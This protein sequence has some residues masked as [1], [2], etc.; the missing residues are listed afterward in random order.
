MDNPQLQELIDSCDCVIHTAGPYYPDQ[1]PTVLEKVIQSSRCQVYLDVS[2]PLPFLQASLDLDTLAKAN[3]KTCLLAAGAFPGLSN[4][5]AMEAAA[6]LLQDDDHDDSMIHNVFFQFFTSGLGGIGDV[7]LYITNLGF[8]E[9]MTQMQDGR[10]RSWRALSGKLLGRVDFGDNIVG[11]QQVFAW[12][13]PEAA[14]VAK[15]LNATGDSV[16]AMGT[17]PDMWNSIMGV[18]VNIVPRSWWRSKRFSKFMADFSQP[19]VKLSDAYLKAADV[20]YGT[21]ETHAMRIDVTRRDSSGVTITQGH[22][23]FRECVGQYAAEFALDCLQH[24]EE[25]GVFLPEQ[26]YREQNARKRI[27]DKLT[28]TPGTCWY[29]GAVATERAVGPNK[30]KQAL[31][32]AQDDEARL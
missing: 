32:Q 28:T 23:S 25:P 13:F 5:L 20:S 31:V 6:Q 17:A 2:D 19:M 18:L 29:S 30:L 12:P 26:R 22:R 1:R 27:V 14:T 21:G 9:P 4:V 16:A 3:N 7:N 11:S 15:E 10:L 24:G 8:G